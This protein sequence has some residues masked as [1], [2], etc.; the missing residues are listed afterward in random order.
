MFTMITILVLCISMQTHAN[1]RLTSTCTGK[2]VDQILAI[3]PIVVEV[4]ARMSHSAHRSHFPSHTCLLCAF[5]LIVVIRLGPKFVTELSTK[6]P[7]PSQFV[8]R[9]T[10]CFPTY[11]NTDK[12]AHTPCY[13]AVELVSLFIYCVTAT[14]LELH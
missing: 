14:M 13:V 2:Y 9:L 5:L 3:H 8:L 1:W 6:R 10:F 12:Y 7:G 4:P 11:A